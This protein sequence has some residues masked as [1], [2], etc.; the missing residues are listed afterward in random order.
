MNEIIAHMDKLSYEMAIDYAI[1]LVH[2]EEKE[3]NKHKTLL[4]LSK[5]HSVP[6]HIYIS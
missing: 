6:S 4:E 1:D 2:S 3:L 5:N